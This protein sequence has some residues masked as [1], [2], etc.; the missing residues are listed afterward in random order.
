MGFAHASTGRMRRRV[1]TKRGRVRKNF[2]F[3]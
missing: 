2:M 1:A 3:E